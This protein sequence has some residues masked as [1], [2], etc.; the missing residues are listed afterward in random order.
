M[1]I[2][3]HPNHSCLNARAS[4]RE[5]SNSCTD[6]TQKKRRNW[7]RWRLEFTD[8]LLISFFFTYNFAPFSAIQ[9]DKR[10]SRSVDSGSVSKCQ[11]RFATSTPPELCSRRVN[12]IIILRG[13]ENRAAYIVRHIRCRLG[14]SDTAVPTV[15]YVC[16]YSRVRPRG[17]MWRTV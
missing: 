17:K 2:W 12:I 6:I 8:F 7:S 4:I 16:S 15:V 10:V 5:K 13:F 1:Y 3:V 9:S 11:W 14:N